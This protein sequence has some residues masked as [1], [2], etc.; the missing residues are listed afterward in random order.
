MRFGDLT[1][2]EAR[3]WLL[4]V[5][6]RSYPLDAQ[7]SRGRT[8]LWTTTHGSRKTVRVDAAE[9]V[10]SDV[11]AV[12]LPALPFGPTPEH[13]SFGAGFIDIPVPAFNAYLAAIL[14]SMSDQRFS[15][16]LV[17]RGCGGHDLRD[18]VN[19]FN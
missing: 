13:R 14:E 15:K 2:E 17:W 10:A 3:L 4:M 9:R 8:C 18:V 5:P 7:S 6:S 12:V 16:I 11:S 19:S 1:F